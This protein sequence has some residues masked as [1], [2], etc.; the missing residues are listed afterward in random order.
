[1]G[2]KNSDGH[3]NQR[4]SVSD[5]W[6]TVV[7]IAAAFIAVGTSAFGFGFKALGLIVVAFAISILVGTLFD[8][9]ISP[10][11]A[12][13]VFT[14]SAVSFAAGI[15][16]YYFSQPKHPQWC[17]ELHPAAP[18][19]YTSG[20]YQSASTLQL[21]RVL[22]NEE[23]GPTSCVRIDLSMLN[24]GGNAV[25]VTRAAIRISRSW[26]ISPTCPLGGKGGGGVLPAANYNSTI[27]LA[28]VP[29]TS[30]VDQVSQHLSPQ[31]VDRFTVTARLTNNPLASQGGMEILEAQ[32]KVYYNNNSQTAWSKPFLFSSDPIATPQNLSNVFGKPNL[33][34]SQSAVIG[35]RV[36]Y[37]YLNRQE[38]ASIAR[39]PVAR[40]GIVENVQR[41]L[42]SPALPTCNQ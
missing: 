32:V 24:K 1:M 31:D 15:G 37:I 12:L 8:A 41:F 11:V 19:A 22:A 27:S 2:S 6:Q 21:V 28:T 35:P 39:M 33:S 14:I 16:Y 34:S 18:S 13:A 42:A 3:R 30:Y 25:F 10:R 20:S 36:N 4:F 38:A 5:R 7:A 29:T 40:T 9:L 26:R 23:N 17:S